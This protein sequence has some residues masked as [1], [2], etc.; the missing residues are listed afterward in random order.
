MVGVNLDRTGTN[1]V[2]LSMCESL[3]W[4]SAENSIPYHNSWQP[5]CGRP[6][7]QV[8]QTPRQAAKRHRT[9]ST[10]G[11]ALLKQRRIMGESLANGGGTAET[12]LGVPGIFGKDAPYGI[13]SALE[14]FLRR[15]GNDQ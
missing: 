13:A 1:N 7:T 12:L 15:S 9:I 11:T 6:D 2:V 8:G 3:I 14:N 10:I 5:T 4:G